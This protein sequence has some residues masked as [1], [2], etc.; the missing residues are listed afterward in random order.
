[1][2]T[3]P[4]RVFHLMQRAHTALFR[5]AD[6]QLKQHLGLSTTQQ[7]VLFMLSLND[8]QAISTIASELSMSKSSLTGVIDRM[9][10][11]GFISRRQA[12]DD[13]RVTLVHIE[14]IGQQLVDSSLPR[15]R[16]MNTSLLQGFSHEE[17][18]TIERFL[19]HIDKNADAIV[20]NAQDPN[21]LFEN[22]KSEQ[23]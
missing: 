6:R 18:N 1:M 13:G 23:P 10:A 14:T 17:Q 8:G 4:F 22:S 20:L 2:K 5:A 16:Q 19:R 15:I 7:S 11:K 9:V 21:L 12:V 3:K